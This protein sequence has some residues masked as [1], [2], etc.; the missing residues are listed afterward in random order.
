[1]SSKP[2]HI[3]AI[4]KT[5]QLKLAGQV[6]NKFL[7][8]IRL[9]PT[10]P[11]IE[12]NDGNHDAEFTTQLNQQPQQRN[13]INPARN[14]NSNPV[15]S[16]QQFIPPNTNQHA[17]RQCMHANMLQPSAQKHVWGQSNSTVPI[18]R[19]QKRFSL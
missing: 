16:P 6:R 14:R 12:M 8:H 1:M 15:P 5:L 9:R 13:R 3:T 4:N 10:Q 7:I 18:T 19:A 11:M 2:S 17:L